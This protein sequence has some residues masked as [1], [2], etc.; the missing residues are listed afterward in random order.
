MNAYSTDLLIGLLNFFRKE[1][2]NHKIGHLVTV[3][4]RDVCKEG[5]GLNQVADAGC[6]NKEN[7][8]L[9]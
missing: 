3:T 4:C 5:F 2:D 8:N 6:L 1:F 9:H 7:S